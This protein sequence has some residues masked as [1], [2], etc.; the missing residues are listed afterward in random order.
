MAGDI[1]IRESLVVA[2]KAA[3]STMP[4]AEAYPSVPGRILHEYGERVLITADAGAARPMAAPTA[5]EAVTDLS[6]VERYGRDAFLL[7]SSAEF[8]RAKANRPNDGQP[9]NMAG[10][11]HPIAPADEAAAPGPEAAAPPGAP[12]P[13]SAYLEGRVAVGVVIVDGP[14]ADLQFTQAERTQ[15]VAE[16]QNGLSWL[17]AQN[18]SA[19]ITWVY[20]IRNVSISTQPDP[21]AADL[22]ALWRDPVMAELGYAASWASVGQYIEDN[23]T[24]LRTRWTYCVFFTKYQLGWF[25]YASIGGP[26]IVMQYA[27]DGWGPDNIDRVF[28][29][30]TGHIFGAPDE[31]ASSGCNCAGN[32][33]RFGQPN[34]NC[35]NCAPSGG[36]DCL[37]K[38]NS[39]TMC[40]RTPAHLGWLSAFPPAR[41]TPQLLQSRFGAKGNFEFV[42]PDASTGIRFSWR[43]NDDPNLL[44]AGTLRF[45]DG[46]GAVDSL[47]MIQSNFGSP[48]NLELIARSGDRLWFFWRDSGPGF[49]WSG[50]FPLFSGARGNPALIQGRF[51]SKGNFEL[52]APAVGGGIWFA[53]RNNDVGNLPWSVPVRFGA[54]AGLVDALTMVQSNFGSPGNL[55]LVSRTGTQ[56]HFFWRDSGPAFNWNGPFPLFGGARGN[57]VLVQ[58]RFGTK[59]NFELVYPASDGGIWFAWRNND[60]GSLP[61]SAPIKFATSIGMVDEITMIQSNFGSPGNLELIA[62]TG[63]RLWF[64]WRDSGPGFQWNGPFELRTAP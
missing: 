33:G 56:L 59:G 5:A 4:G 34:V 49:R 32:W 47:S 16:V 44:W 61:W 57:P 13:T 10:C 9:W 3:P 25:A 40:E 14:T 26:R 48:G 51:G 37:M 12:G 42:V 29:H 23:R 6:E 55:E 54:R 27:N 50:P 35:Q 1:E 52:V 64:F 31:Y 46:L 2:D 7:R 53:W 41:G 18:A 11:H 36:V 45:G 24:R 28:T 20:D 60:S 30:E 63:S 8:I 15:V 38:G 58:S 43:N 21:G 19:G 22:E 39:W 62:R 17:A